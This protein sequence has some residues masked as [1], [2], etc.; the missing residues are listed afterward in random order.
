MILALT[1]MDKE[2][3]K[4]KWVASNPFLTGKW[5]GE[6]IFMDTA[7]NKDYGHVLFEI[8]INNDLTISGRVGEARL[9][10][11][12]ISGM[13]NR[14]KI[15]GKLNVK[16]K[17]DKNASWDRVIFYINLPAEK[18]DIKSM[19]ASFNL[20]NNYFFDVAMRV[21]IVKLNKEF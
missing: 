4:N 16:I 18:N 13:H 14:I 12:H 17:K 11:T 6:G 3:N 10:V 20:K 9:T 8:E 5:T 21:G 2:A 7:I 1:C 19:D 15:K